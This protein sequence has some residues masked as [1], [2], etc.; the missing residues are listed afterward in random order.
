MKIEGNSRKMTTHL[1]S[2]I[3][4]SLRFGEA[5][6]DLNQYIGQHIHFRFLNEINCIAC[7]KATKKSF[8]QGFCY[9]CMMNSPDN[10]ECIIRP[11]LCRGHLGEGR[12][13]EWEQ[14]NHVCEHVVYLAASS[15]MKVGVTRGQQV[16]TRFIDQG[17][18]A[19]KIIA[20][21]PHRCAAGEIEVALKEEFTDRTSWQKMLKN[22]VIDSP[23]WDDAFDLAER[24]V[25]FMHQEYLIDDEPIIDLN[26]PVLEYPTKV[27]SLSFD[28]LE[29]IEGKLMGIK[30]QYLLFDDNRVLNIRKHNGYQL[31]FEA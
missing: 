29:V 17:A 4:Y 19:V 12:D 14:K 3:E 5:S 2:T 30:G 21:T 24:I 6:C 23:D 10:A 7:G 22:D 1:G 28:K 27:K 15:A 20:R 8:A 13:P 9:P 25:P 16:P 31:A 18:S 26:F 11:E